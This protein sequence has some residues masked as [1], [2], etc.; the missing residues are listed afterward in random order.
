MNDEFLMNARPAVRPEFA[1]G[2]YQRLNQ[3]TRLERANAFLRTRRG[4]A[5]ALAALLLLAACAQQVLSLD[6][7]LAAELD[8]IAVYEMNYRIVRLPD[9]DYSMINDWQAT[10]AEWQPLGAATT[11]GEAPYVL[12]LPINLP[13][14]FGEPEAMTQHPLWM[15]Q[16]Q[17]LTHV[18]RWRTESGGSAIYLEVASR[19]REPVFLSIGSAGHTE[20]DLAT[21][22]AGVRTF[23]LEALTGEFQPLKLDVAPEKWEEIEVNGRPA[24][25]VRGDWSLPES[26]LMQLVLMQDNW[27]LPPAE[28]DQPRA[29]KI[30]WE[31]TLGLHLYWADGNYIF[32]L[33]AYSVTLQP[34]DLIA[35]A[36]SIH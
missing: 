32:H 2:L 14:G 25:L 22:P 36:E 35:I 24:V 30:Y 7:H 1:A 31:D 21:P 13:A 27:I 16:D 11:L 33:A 10:T 29:E 20:D 9:R 18:L 34:E 15:D 17:P 26:T 5:T 6:Y 28:D 12:T 8:G 23:A 4:L 19:K 3:P